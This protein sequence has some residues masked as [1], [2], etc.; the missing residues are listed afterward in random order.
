[1]NNVAN[2]LLKG[3][4]WIT[5]ARV[6]VNVLALLTTF[7]LARLLMPADF[8]L[9][10]LCTTLMLVVT[11]VTEL[12]LAQA[13]VRHDNPTREH[14]DTAWTLNAC[15]GLIIGLAFGLAAYPLAHI[16][17]DPR[18]VG[19][20][21]VLGVSIALTGFANPRRILLTRQLIFRPEFVLNVGQK[22]AGV[23]VSVLIAYW[24]QSY[25]ALVFGILA[26]NATNVLLSYAVLPYMPKIRFTHTRE[27]FSFS[28]WLTAVQ[29]VNSL[30]WRFDVLFVGKVLGNEALGHYSMGN[31]LASLPTRETTGP[32]R[33][34]LFPAFASMRDDNARMAA[35][36]QRAQGI[37]T[38]IALPAGIGAAFIADPLIRLTM[39]EKWVPTI[40]I[41]QMLAAI[42]ALQTIGSSAESLGMAKGATR[43]LFVRSVQMLL[44]RVPMILWAMWQF[45]MTGLITARV[46]TGLFAIWINLHI[47]RQLVGL[48]MVA[49]LAYN[50]R[51]LISTA[52]MAAAAMGATSLFPTLAAPPPSMLLAQMLVV[53]AVAVTSFVV[54]VFLLWSLLGRP[55]GP[56]Q[57][58]LDLFR[59]LKGKL[60]VFRA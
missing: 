40:F 19:I 51:L 12:S 46:L 31:T 22:F 48:G 24:Y 29:V 26:T 39:G 54:V 1:M 18:L 2:R 14:F 34:T 25:W 23:V 59:K 5:G 20:M 8:G 10:A 36:Y 47:V 56:E 11:E 33:Q 37:I 57:E 60:L 3:T 41:V 21:G 50:A 43:L 30:N 17:G 52:F 15:R 13:L 6:I 28:L 35:A 49:Q 55:A 58:V 53:G 27:L 45:G 44:V 4:A 16:Y 9:V 42:L 7:V 32:L 38:L